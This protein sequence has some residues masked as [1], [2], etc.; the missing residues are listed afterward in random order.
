MT[1]KMKDEKRDFETDIKDKQNKI[2]QQK[3]EID[4]I[5]NEITELRQAN[6]GL[7]S[8]KFS[9]EKSLTEFQLKQ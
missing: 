9:Q 2:E 6:K 7:D 8:T 5:R 3:H 4:L 1:S